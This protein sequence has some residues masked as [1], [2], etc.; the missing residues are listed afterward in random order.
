MI[1]TDFSPEMVD[2]A[3]ANGQALGL[4]NV[5]YRVMDAENMELLEENIVDG[6]VCRFGYMLMATRWRR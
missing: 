3:R 1:S 5:E 4:A 6:V 2:V